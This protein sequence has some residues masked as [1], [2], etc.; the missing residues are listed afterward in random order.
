MASN[1]IFIICVILFTINT[2]KAQAQSPQNLDTYEPAIVAELHMQVLSRNLEGLKQ[3]LQLYPEYI[4][5]IN[6]NGYSLLQSAAR[7]DDLKVVEFLLEAGAD[8][9]LKNAANGQNAALHYARSPIVIQRLIAYRADINIRNARGNSP[10]LIYIT[11]RNL[12]AENTHVLLE[13]GASTDIVSR[14]RGGLSALHLIFKA[15]VENREGYLLI[16]LQKQRIDKT[17]L[18]IARDL[19]AHGIDVN[20]L[21]EDGFTAL[22][23]AARLGNI[24]GIKL[25]V[26]EGANMDIVNFKYK[27]TPMMY[28]FGGRALESVEKL[29]LLR[30][31]FNIKDHKG[32]SAEKLIRW[33]AE[34][35]DRFIKLVHIIDKINEEE[36]RK[37][38]VCEVALT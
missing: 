27:Q 24:E 7:F 18:E 26:K 28:A 25:L 10:L 19:I 34:R 31:R 12:S 8:V 3:R 9:D 30:A 36:A 38:L 23:F 33:Y 17:R 37:T 14:D 16:P 32:Y 29:L 1:K 22:H 13:A 21:T 11:R 4:D 5:A 35:D 2:S 15:N 6:H 20:V